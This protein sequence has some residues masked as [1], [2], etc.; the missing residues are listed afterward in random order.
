MSAVT[1][2]DIFDPRGRASRTGLI[3]V[4][5]VLVGAQAGMALGTTATGGDVPPGAAI[6]ANGAFLWLGYV[7]VSKRL[8][9]LGY[10]A[11]SLLIG[12]AAVMLG[13]IAVAFSIMLTA[14]EDALLPGAAGYLAVAAA[15]FAPVIAAT[16][17]LHCAPGEKRTNRFGRE[18]GGHGFS[19]SADTH[20][21]PVAAH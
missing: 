13:A 4:A 9:D 8:H 2:S 16:L 20:T 18:P 5:V 3:A 10:G 17:W 12:I 6:V 14:G 15:V 1:L 7:A 11:G 19:R 21:G